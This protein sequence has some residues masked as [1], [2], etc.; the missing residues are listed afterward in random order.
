MQNRFVHRVM[1]LMLLLA[2][3]AVGWYAQVMQVLA[4][5]S[6]YCIHEA[7]HGNLT[8]QQRDAL[9]T[10]AYDL[11]ARLQRWFNLPLCAGLLVIVLSGTLL[12]AGRTPAG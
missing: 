5:R 7:Q 1:L 8:E 2:G 11:N 4:G 9:L 3:I 6:A 12:A 10:E